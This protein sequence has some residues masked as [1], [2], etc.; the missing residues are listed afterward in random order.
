MLQV[1][2]PCPRAV[3]SAPS[4]RASQAPSKD[5]APAH[6]SRLTALRHNRQPTACD[7]THDHWEEEGSQPV[8]H[9]HCRGAAVYMLMLI[10]ARRELR[11]ATKV[12]CQE[13]LIFHYPQVRVPATYRRLATWPATGLRANEKRRAIDFATVRGNEGARR[14]RESRRPALE[15][16]VCRESAV[17]APRSSNK[18]LL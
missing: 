8:A 6:S 17:S 7:V 10:R 5:S 18:V 1:L 2:E 14:E 12:P 16:A 13:G 11:V 3:T 9:T 4:A 15:L